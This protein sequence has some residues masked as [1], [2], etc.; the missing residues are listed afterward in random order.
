M[1]ALLLTAHAVTAVVSAAG[2]FWEENDDG[3]GGS[4]SSMP[5][6]KSKSGSEGASAGEDLDAELE[7]DAFMNSSRASVTAV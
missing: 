2:S 5:A 1:G 7:F 3:G 6:S 4:N